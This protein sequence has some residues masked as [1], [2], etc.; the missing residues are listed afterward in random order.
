MPAPVSSL[1]AQP[2][3]PPQHRIQPI[4]S[5]LSFVPRSSPSRR[6]RGWQHITF[7][8]TPNTNSNLPRI[9]ESIPRKGPAPNFPR[10]PELSLQEP[11][12]WVQREAVNSRDGWVVLIFAAVALAVVIEAA[13]LLR[14]TF[15]S[16]LTS[17]AA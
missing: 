11:V 3:C 17:I 15:S 2:D 6:R 8:L 4:T 5:L 12:Q 9:I 13:M 14:V 7:A 1:C 10:F 16:L